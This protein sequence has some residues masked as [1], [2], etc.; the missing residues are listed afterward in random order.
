MSLSKSNVFSNRFIFKFLD[1]LKDHPG[2]KKS[3]N[4]PLIN[5]PTF[6]CRSPTDRLMA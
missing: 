3:V 2:F 1:S 5:S 4:H 6:D